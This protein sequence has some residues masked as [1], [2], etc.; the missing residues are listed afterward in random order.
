VSLAKAGTQPKNGG[1]NSR[2]EPE[3]NGVGLQEVGMI[4]ARGGGVKKCS[5]RKRNLRRRDKVTFGDKEENNRILVGFR[6]KKLKRN[7]EREERTSK[8]E[9][10]NTVE[11]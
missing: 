4:F 11:V 6:V 3:E 10:N 7:D 9:K 2:T 8:G 5:R 1:R